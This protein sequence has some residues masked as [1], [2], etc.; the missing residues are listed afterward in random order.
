MDVILSRTQKEIQKAAWEFAK[1]E[2]DAAA[3]IEMDHR[4]YF[5]APIWKKSAELGF[6]GLH[7]AEA[8]GGGGMGLLET[9]LV[10][11]ALCRRSSTMGIAIGL[12]D[13]LAECLSLFGSEEQKQRYLPSI[14]EGR[15][16]CGICLND[17]N[18]DA[19]DNAT[20]CRTTG[21]G[22]HIEISGR[23]PLVVN[24]PVAGL[25]ILLC[26]DVDAPDSEQAYSLVLVSGQDQGVALRPVKGKLGMRLTSMGELEL[27]AVHVP[28]ANRLGQKGQGRMHLKAATWAFY[29][30]SA[31]MALGIAQGALDRS[32][33]YA[34]KRIQFR[35]KIGQF[36]VTRHK[37]AQ[38]VMLV[39]QARCLTYA[40]AA[41]MDAKR[42]DPVL[43][44]AAKLC[45]CNAAVKV[46]YE[47][48]QLHGG[49][50]YMTEYEVERFYRD[51]KMLQ[52][53]GGNTG[54]LKDEL[55]NLV[56]GKLS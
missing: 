26:R 5:P 3:I 56:I 37:L 21:D 48:I 45:A 6:I 2:F 1:G 19:S 51:A 39:E 46:A 41:R 44:A 30:K 13:V 4:E 11:E 18:P 9:V 40:A 32:L 42:P 55:A 49:Y 52:I 25:Y 43:S 31:G 27:Q 23:W 8:Y 47:A 29:V 53:A 15:Q 33:D 20:V 22:L 28:L 50:G 7:A 14:C 54:M 17:L 12:A 35:R 34:R 36:Q 16:L 24:A 38:M 10:V